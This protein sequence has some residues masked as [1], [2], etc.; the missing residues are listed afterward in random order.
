MIGEA[1]KYGYIVELEHNKIQS[2]NY[3]YHSSFTVQAHGNYEWL[4]S[5]MKLKQLH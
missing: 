5:L 3:I 2:Q 4:F 1:W